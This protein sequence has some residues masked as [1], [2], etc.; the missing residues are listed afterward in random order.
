MHSDDERPKRAGPG[1][2][3][4]Q[5]NRELEQQLALL[6]STLNSTADGILVA[7][8]DGRVLFCNDNYLR[9]L[10][11]ERS[12][13]DGRSHADVIKSVSEQ[14][15]DPM[16]FLERVEAIYNSLE[17]SSFDV[18]KTIDGRVYE[19]FSRLQQVDGQSVGRVWSFRDISELQDLNET[20]EQRVAERTSALHRSEEQFQQLV[21][22]VRD[23][24]I[25]M[26]DRT[27]HIVSWNPGAERIKGYTSLEIIGRHF[28]LFYTDEDRASG[29]PDR[30][31]SIAAREGKYEREAWRV[32]KDGTRFW[33]NVL[34]DAI[35]DSNDQLIGFAKITR[36]MTERRAM[37]EQ[38]HQS[39][40]MEAVG[41][42]TG[43]V[44]HDFNNLLTVIL[45]NL[46]SIERHAGNDERLRRSVDQAM[47]GAQRAATLTQQLLAFARRQPLDP[48][49]ANVNDLVVDMSDLI[50]R[51]L[52]ENI[53]IETALADDLWPVE[54]DPHQ[55][56]SAILNL[57]VNSRDAMPRGGRLTVKTS[58]VSIDQKPLPIGDDL[59]A[60][61]YI[62]I[63][64]TDTG[65]GMSANVLAHAFDPFFTTK[66]TGEGTGLGLS[67][68]F[69]FVKQSGGH[70]NLFSEPDKGTCVHIYLPRLMGDAASAEP[71]A[72]VQP[73]SAR[74][75]ET[76]LSVEDDDDVRMYTS[77]S[78]REL[79]FTVIEAS[80][81]PTALRVLAQHP[82]IKLLFSD[83][84]L[85]RMNGRQLMDEARL[86]RPDIKVLF[87]SGYARQAI[88]HDGRL[89]QGV[90]LLTKPFTRAQLGERVR[91]VLDSALIAA[92]SPSRVAV[93]I[94]DEVLIS[95][96]LADVLEDIGFTVI[97]SHSAQGGLA[98]VEGIP[99][100]DVAFVDIGLPDRSGLELA[101]EMRSRFPAL[102]IAI[103]S[104]YSEQSSSIP[105]DD[106]NVIFLPKP[107][108][109]AAIKRTLQ[110]LEVS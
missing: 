58:N 44:A 38:L 109:A 102:K 47:R 39:Q 96:Y 6:R 42:L 55:L 2:A 66:P 19:R 72:P 80:D 71:E 30:T 36:D 5:K 81:G 92:P 1:G 53:T 21:N 100:A 48:R 51:T 87:T 64:V 94:D 65:T 83:V 35:H 59:G 85:P 86:L 95:M 84:G 69:G 70:V 75:D 79:G 88:V 26:L 4:E 43:G 93:V 103:A 74:G 97:Q 29:L 101:S 12:R 68:V 76:I 78:L 37:Q 13:V 41:H 22:G 11:L 90:E 52:G 49:R 27:G 23:C 33:A 28:S 31:L 99:R 106:P 105:R 108:D 67:Q 73:V 40:K 62:L 82:E 8:P 107:F 61:D 89:D 63:A 16:A 77:E 60:G 50:G 20:L 46:E 17:E 104:G 18:M 10:K 15:E 110:A 56:E 14:F 24:A 32:R 98:A 3:L 54:V 57:A 7:D 25:Y 9:M 45:G 91:A 34:I